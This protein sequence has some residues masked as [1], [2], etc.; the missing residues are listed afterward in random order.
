[1]RWGCAQRCRTR[2][3]VVHGAAH[4][5]TLLQINKQIEAARQAFAV[6][7]YRAEV[8][9]NKEIA[10]EPLPDLNRSIA[11]NASGVPKPVFTAPPLPA[12]TAAPPATLRS[13][14]TNLR[15]VSAVSARAA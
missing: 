5:G 14:L 10:L 2:A 9:V 1:M 6:R 12:A 8:S 7:T 11:G 15:D 4:C 13:F 3:P